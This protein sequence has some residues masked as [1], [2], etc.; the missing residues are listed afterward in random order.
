MRTSTIWLGALALAVITGD[1][2]AQDR[3]KQ[4]QKQE[5]DRAEARA[6]S[7]DDRD[8]DRAVRVLRL[9]GDPDRAVLGVSTGSSGDR[10]TLG[11]LITS[12]T[13]GS[14]AEKAGLEEGNRIASI[15]GVNLRVAAVDA[16]E[17]D[18]RGL[19]TRRLTREMAKVKAGDEVELRV[20]ASGA[21]RNVKVKTVA[22]E[23]MAPRRVRLDRD[24]IDARPA[25][26]VN[27][28]SNGSKRDTLGVLVV[29]VEEN[30]PAEKAG[31][32]EG[33]RIQAIAGT[34][35][36][37]RG[38]DAGDPWVSSAKAARLR[39]ALQSAKV[40]ERVE[41]RVWSGGQTK[42][43]SVTP[44][45]AGE[46]YKRDRARVWFGESGFM[47]PPMA[48]VPPT[49]PMPP[50]PPTE[51]RFYMD[52]G[53]VVDIDV[54]RIIDGAMLRAQEAVERARVAA[55]RRLRIVAPPAMQL[56]AAPAP[57]PR[58]RTYVRMVS[59]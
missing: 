45:R 53:P 10:D 26:G 19:T 50:M 31:L 27:L 56:Q 2:G 51:G 42:T 22:A 35:V 46:L 15:N 9:G 59:L 58:A 13:P 8:E 28:S 4:R 47:M 40:G 49:P 24:S 23:S 14:P 38:E 39:R 20:W 48:P 17:S 30:G 34:D 33:D 18:M 57:A 16:G 21:Y 12:V 25:I 5:R 1:A 6:E 41:L 43:V 32:I 7:R 36:R 55:P 54:E 3:A 44:V 52:G 29:G 37:V 11:L